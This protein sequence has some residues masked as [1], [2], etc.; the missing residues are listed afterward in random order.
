MAEPVGSS[1]MNRPPHPSLHR[2]DQKRQWLAA[3]GLPLF[4][5]VTCWIVFGQVTTFDFVGYDDPIYVGLRPDTRI[6]SEGLTAEGLAW[7]WTANT[8][9]LWE[10]LNYLSH[11][12][13]VECFGATS[14]GAGGH[15]LTNL[16]LH[17]IN[18]LLVYLLL[19]SIS[20]DDLSAFAATL[21]FAIHPMRAESV[22][23][24]SERKGLLCATFVLS[25]L[26]SYLRYGRTS[27]RTFWWL[28]LCFTALGMMT[29]PAA[30]VVPVLFVLMDW[31]PLQRCGWESTMTLTSWR[32]FLK[33]QTREK[34]PCVLMAAGLVA[35]SIGV[36]Y[37]SHQEKFIGAK[38]FA[39]RVSLIPANIL[40][41][42]QRTIWPRN[43]A[44][45]YPE[46]LSH[47]PIWLGAA[48]AILVSWAAVA[49]RKVVPAFMFGWVWFLICWLPVSGLA[50]V[51]ASFTTDR[52]MY[53]AHIGVFFGIVQC[54]RHLGSN[55]SSRPVV[56]ATTIGLA[57]V[58]V[59]ASGVLCWRQSSTWKNDLTLFRHAV[60]TQPLVSSGY[61]NLAVAL[62]RRGH[63]ELAIPILEESQ[64]IRDHFVTKYNLARLYA[65][66]PRR[67][68][69]ARELYQEAIADHPDYSEAWHNLGRLEMRTATSDDQLAVAQDHIAKA[70]ELEH[71]ANPLYQLSLVEVLM[72]R[73]Q[74]PAAKR[75]CTEALRGDIRSTRIHQE[76]LARQTQL[77]AKLQPALQPAGTPESP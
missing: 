50:Y 13:D 52:Y 38:S 42:F 61:T 2:P 4:F 74:W 67:V 15:H 29:K 66:D 63:P 26:L 11:M 77:E 65:R 64:L 3:I 9:S 73:Q 40:F 37:G 44:V 6:I 17:S 54:V 68:D 32:T 57:V 53:L 58:L 43:L 47:A 25:A 33:Q 70:A 56:G 41:Y 76:L 39:D 12:F 49:S 1:N 7:I 60:E 48:F 24:I 59:I 36:Q 10:P 45:E 35:V 55:L 18:V 28:S 21:L 22:A 71:N 20:R 27:N 51:G 8:N 23:W 5:V 69:Q 62:E 14:A 19:W 31:W 46:P 34:W 75:V 16:V 30:V 72:R